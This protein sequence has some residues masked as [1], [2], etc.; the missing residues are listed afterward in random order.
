[1]LS[2]RQKML[3]GFGGLVLII[4][5]LSLLIVKDFQSITAETLIN[6]DNLNTLLPD[7]LKDIFFALATLFLLFLNLILSYAGNLKLYFD[8]FLS[9]LRSRLRTSS[10]STQTTP[11]R[12]SRGTGRLG[13]L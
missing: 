13:L 1:M 8:K 2:L 7:I 6:G 11:S 4:A 10:S 3:I 9:V 5:I 12:V